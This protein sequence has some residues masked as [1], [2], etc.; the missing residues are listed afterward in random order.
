MS[1]GLRVLVIEDDPG[2]REGLS[3]LFRHAPG[4][5]LGAQF[6]SPL[7]PLLEL[8]RAAARGAPP[9]WDL[10]VSDVELPDASGIEVARRVKAAYPELPVVLLTVF[11]EPDTILDA[12]RAG[13]DGYLL[14][15]AAT[16]EILAGLRAVAAGGSTLTAAVA[17]SVLDLL[18][19]EAPA[20]S[21]EPGAAA[22][23]RAELTEREQEILRGLT[24]GLSYEQLAEDLEISL[25]TVRT[26]IR[27]VYRK[28]QVHS[29]RAAV[30]RAVRDRLV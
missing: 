8:E 4:F 17:R 9:P 30:S 25:G 29:A 11:E 21:G 6:G 14:K 7:V 18:R 22:P 3:A 23:H 10:V 2:Y 1:G 28:L 26:H 24:H 27:A 20:G 19:R 15:R 5:E 16:G 13:A 12:I